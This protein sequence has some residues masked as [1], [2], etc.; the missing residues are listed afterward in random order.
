MQPVGRDG[1]VGRQPEHNPLHAADHR[2][3]GDTCSVQ[4]DGAAHT[5]PHT[6]RR[7]LLDDIRADE[8]S[9]R[10]QVAPV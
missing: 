10:S 8:A 1:P 5:F 9:A 3:G 4:G 6:R 7:H 2:S